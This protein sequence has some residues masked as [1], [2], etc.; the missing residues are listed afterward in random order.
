MAKRYALPAMPTVVNNM[1]EG[2]T[3]VVGQPDEKSGVR[4]DLGLG[5]DVPLIVH[6]GVAVPVRG[7]DTIVRALAE[8]ELSETHF[9]ML[10][11]SRRGHVEDLTRLAESLG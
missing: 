11:G 5:P 9:A 10:V 1:P 8:P 4:G 2:S 7:L 6:A 3:L